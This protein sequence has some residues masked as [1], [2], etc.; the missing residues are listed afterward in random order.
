MNDLAQVLQATNRLKEAEPLLRSAL[1][2]DEAASGSDHPD[3][4]IGLNNLAQLLMDT[5]RLEEAEL[6][7]FRMLEI[8]SDFRKKTGHRHPHFQLERDDERN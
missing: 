5:K 7:M 3:V 1:K 8:F 4:A 2:I 6:L